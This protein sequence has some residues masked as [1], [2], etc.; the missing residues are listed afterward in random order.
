MGFA[1]FHGLEQR[2]DPIFLRHIALIIV[3]C[4]LPFQAVWFMIHAFVMEHHDR[5]EEDAMVIL[6]RLQGTCQLVSYLSMTG[7]ALMFYSIHWTIGVAFLLS[8]AIA[9]LMVRLAISQA[10]ELAAAP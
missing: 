8:G 2:A 1:L 4:G 3:V 7:M 6:S 5:I 10:D 9:V